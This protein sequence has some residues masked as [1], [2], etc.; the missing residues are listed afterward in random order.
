MRQE[1]KKKRGTT[2]ARKGTGVIK[3]KK[4]ERKGQ[5]EEINVGEKKPSNGTWEWRRS[6]RK[7]RG[8]KANHQEI[9]QHEEET[10]R[11]RDER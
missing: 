9:D 10:F 6:G 4:E 5:R 2:K 11:I 8:K 3:K 7:K 1:R